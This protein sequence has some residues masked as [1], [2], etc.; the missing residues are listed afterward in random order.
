MGSKRKDKD[1]T[2]QSTVALTLLDFYMLCLSAAE[3]CKNLSAVRC[4]EQ[5]LRACVCGGGC[6]GCYWSVFYCSLDAGKSSNRWGNSKVLIVD[7]LFVVRQTLRG[8]LKKNS[9]NWKVIKNKQSNTDHKYS[10]KFIQFI[11]SWFLGPS[12][13][14][15]CFSQG[16]ISSCTPWLDDDREPK[17]W[18]KYNYN[19][20]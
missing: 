2:E 15:D 4:E 5:W 7:R 14:I 13:L 1:S 3:I 10:V 17:I 11:Y 19:N 8:L 12:P 18:I 6:M 20:T 9:G 16:L